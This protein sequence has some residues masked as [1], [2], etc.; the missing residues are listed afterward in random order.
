MNSLRSLVLKSMLACQEYVHIPDQS[1]E[2]YDELGVALSKVESILY[3][4][5]VV[6]L[7]NRFNMFTV[8][9]ILILELN[10]VKSS[11]ILI[12]VD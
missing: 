5:I 1:C 6:F 7:A 2:E 12:K 4:I 10:R 11:W 8:R 9:S 3:C